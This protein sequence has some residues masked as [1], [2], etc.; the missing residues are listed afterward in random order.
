M[1]IS[2]PSC[3]KTYTLP[4]ELIVRIVKEHENRASQ[5]SPEAFFQSVSDSRVIPPPAPVYAASKIGRGKDRK[6]IGILKA[7]IALVTVLWPVG[8]VL[9][10]IYSMNYWTQKRFEMGGGLYCIDNRNFISREALST[11]TL[12]ESLMIGT[13]VWGLAVTFLGVLHLATRRSVS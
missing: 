13:G 6:R 1:K 12:L 5:S 7:L 3:G 2:C 11:K 10:W 9:F 4:P 8:V